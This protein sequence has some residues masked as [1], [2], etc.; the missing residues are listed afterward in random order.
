MHT[1]IAAQFHTE[2]H[3]LITGARD[4]SQTLFTDKQPCLCQRQTHRKE[5]YVSAYKRAQY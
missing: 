1:V 4:W 5:L 3:S 2:I